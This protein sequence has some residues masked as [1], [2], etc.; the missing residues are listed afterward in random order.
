MISASA[1]DFILLATIA[2]L[3]S[4]LSIMILMVGKYKLPIYHPFFIYL[5]YHFLG[6]V[7]R[8]YSIY[9]NSESFLWIRIGIAPD[10]GDIIWASFISCVALFS[11]TLGLILSMKEP[12]IKRLPP[13]RIVIGNYYYFIGAVILLSLLGYYGTYK[14]YFGAGLD[15]VLAYKTS[16]DAGGGQRLVGVSGYVTA[17]AEFL[18]IVCIILFLSKKTR[19]FSYIFIGVF[20][21]VRFYAGAQR[22]SFV[23]VLAALFLVYHIDNKIR[24]P[25]VAPVIFILLFAF[26]FDIIGND[27][28]AFRKLSMGETD[29]TSILE[30]YV[31]ER[32]G[33]ALTSDIVEYD[34]ATAVIKVVDENEAFSYGT[35]YLR[36]LIWPI[37]RQIWAEKP[38][39]TSIVDLND[40]GDFRYLTT[41]LYAD[42]YMVFGLGSVLI[43]MFLL[44]GFMGKIYEKTRVGH[45]IYIY[46]FFWVFLIYIKTI[47]RDGGVTVVYFW[48][49]S[50]IAAAILIYFG[51]LSL[52]KIKEK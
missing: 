20:V 3:L 31:D 49:F 13:T 51:K 21:A 9:S 46:A 25:K 50:M 16:L 34:V 26:V 44:G 32:G 38:V 22:L 28:Y 35:Q 15:S 7:L 5:I 1:L 11:I 4:W 23:V 45:N 17:L 27:R 39:Y 18:P 12:V 6:Y 33:N 52:C 41:S 48:I 19:K 43:L 42:T 37:P 8:P 47:L 24:Y 2:N 10:G 40:F 36:L 14:S 29:I 30:N